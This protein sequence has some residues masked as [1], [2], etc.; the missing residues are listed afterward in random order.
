MINSADEVLA[1]LQAD[2]IFM[3]KVGTYTFTTGLTETALVVL[4]S[5]QTIPG[6]KEVSG[7]EVVINR[8]PDTTTRAVIAGCSIREKKWTIYL[9]QYENSE[10]NALVEAADRLMDLAPGASYGVL[11]G[12]FQASD[13][14]GIE[15]A[16]AK[17]PAH[18][19]LTAQ[20]D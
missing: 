14:A 6:I 10:P 9:V 1:H 20:N 3:S 18:S 5:N 7:V 12:T 4:G 19:V 11:G 16:V 13:I 17:I 15:Q 2:A 8:V